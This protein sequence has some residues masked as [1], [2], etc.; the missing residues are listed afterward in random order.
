MPP[1]FKAMYLV[2]CVHDVLVVVRIWWPPG[3]HGAHAVLFIADG[4]IAVLVQTRGNIQRVVSSRHVPTQMFI[5]DHVRPP[6]AHLT[7]QEPVV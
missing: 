4:A 3:K 5:V 6:D 7:Q 1:K 2:R